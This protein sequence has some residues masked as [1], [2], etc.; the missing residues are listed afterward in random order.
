PL[1]NSNN[2]DARPATASAS[3]PATADPNYYGS[4]DS[5]NFTIDKAASTTTVNGPA[6]PYTYNGSAQSPCSASVTGAGGLSQ[7]LTVTYSDNANAG[8]AT[9]SAS[10]GGDTNHDGSNDS[11][12]FTIDKAASTTTVTCPAGPYTYNGSAQ[13]P[14]TAPVTDAGGLSQALTLTD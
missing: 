8:Q 13:S 11:Q 1:S 2:A 12:H 14:C 6:G 9:A 4:S 3:Y 5:K 7:S 10:Y